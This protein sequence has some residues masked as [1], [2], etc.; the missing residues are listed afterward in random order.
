MPV[1]GSVFGLV[2]GPVLDHDCA[3]DLVFSMFSPVPQSDSVC[4]SLIQSDPCS[5]PCSR[6]VLALVLDAMLSL[7]SLIQSDACSRSCSRSVLAQ[8]SN[9]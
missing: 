5:R 2:L 1:L 3:S 7:I 9:A 6:G 8:F 4:P